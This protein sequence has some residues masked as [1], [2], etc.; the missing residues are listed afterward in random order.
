MK[1]VRIYSTVDPLPG[2]ALLPYGE[3]LV[4]NE[5]MLFNCD[6]HHAYELGGPI[7]RQFIELLPEEWKEGPVVIDSRV[8]MLMPGWYAC[9][10]G[11]HHDDVPRPNGGQP[12]YD[13]PLRSRHIV[14]L[15][16]ADLCPTEF[17]LGTAMM[18]LPAPDAV[19][20]EEWHRD[21]E[22]MLDNRVLT[23]WNIPDLQLV[24]FDDRTFHQGTAAIR[25]GW[26]FFIR[27]SRYYN[28]E[29]DKRIDRG[30]PRTNEVR[31]QVQV[32]MD[33]PHKGW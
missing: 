9:I 20:Y 5:P 1:T 11:W 31:R 28:V 6:L 33:N 27:C 14:A 24:E 29:T 3:N 32:Y 26:R 7:T 10:P 16:N 4:K 13:S 17:A 23:R 8:H 15:V 19:L 30:N 22:Y 2:R 18:T 21:V 25:S 12:D